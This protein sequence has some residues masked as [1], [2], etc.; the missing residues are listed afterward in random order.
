[1]VEFIDTGVG[2]PAENINRIFDP[3]FSTKATGT[4]LGLFVCYSVVEGHHG[5]IEAQSEV[6]KGT[7][8]TV[9]LPGYQE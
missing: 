8:F 5:T 1:V 7:R 6:G 3:F 2:I 4:G 9:K